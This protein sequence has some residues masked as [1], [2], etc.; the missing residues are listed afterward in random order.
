MSAAE[1]GHMHGRPSPDR[2]MRGVGREISLPGLEHPWN[3]GRCSWQVCG[4]QQAGRR[5][6]PDSRCL[7]CL[8]L[9]E[10]V[11]LRLRLQ[12]RGSRPADRVQH[13]ALGSQLPGSI[14]T[15]FCS[16]CHLRLLDMHIGL[17][18][19]LHVRDGGRQHPVQRLLLHVCSS[20]V[21]DLQRYPC[22][23]DLAKHARELRLQACVAGHTTF[24]ATAVGRI[25]G[26]ESRR[27]SV[28][29]THRC[30]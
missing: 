18:R 13:G 24:T 12:W 19:M 10:Q 9:S 25:D 4:R 17:S 20:H 7:R 29:G 22:L 6:R 23:A 21:S 26:G 1:F 2:P 27:S 8:A 28:S 15:C 11:L 5:K 3:L 14:W 16:E 30:H